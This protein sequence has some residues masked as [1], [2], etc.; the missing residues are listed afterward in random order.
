MQHTDL[1]VPVT[2]S[3]PGAPF[4]PIHQGRYEVDLVTAGLTPPAPEVVAAVARSGVRVLRVGVGCWLPSKDPDP[5][6]VAIREWFTGSTLADTDDESCYRWEHLDRNIDACAAFGCE[7]LLAVDYMPATLARPAENFSLPPEIAAAIPSDYTFPDGVRT[8]PPADPEVFAAAA[9]RLVDHVAARGVTIRGV[10]LWNEPDL[11]IF[12]SG[13]Y[14][15]W[16][17]MYRPFSRL[18][19]AGGYR[20]GGPSWA[21][22]LEPESWV[23]RFISDVAGE[24]LPLDFYSFHR[25]GRTVE[26]ILTTCR[27]VRS[28]LDAAGLADTE[29]WIDEWG[30]AL[31]DA[32]FFGTVGNAAFVAACLMAMPSVG[33]GLQTNILLV[34]P[35]PPEFGRFHGLVRQNGEPNPVYW[36]IDA[37]ERFGK[38]PRVVALAVEESGAAV[39]GGV[40]DSGERMTVLL[41]NPTPE[42]LEV[43]LDIEGG[44]VVSPAVEVLTQDGFDRHAGWAAG[45]ATAATSS[46][47]VVALEP[48]SL[49]RLTAE[50]A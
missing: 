14:D 20:V 41:A 13:S 49:A 18:M 8:A 5:A 36:T 35:L 15:E 43:C 46:E 17:A 42:P 33:I 10:E 1:R 4:P 48:W 9:R 37:F 44:R 16:I 26:K 19:A 7:V 11:P 50:V 25:Y 21:G 28:A 23:H 27:E 47:V 29:A 12:Y 39:I 30:W 45:A 2:L 38:T 3:A 40:D 6:D 32:P 31:D 34:D 24:G 22:L